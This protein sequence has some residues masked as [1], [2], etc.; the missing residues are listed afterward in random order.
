[1]F[2]FLTMQEN[3]R[4]LYLGFCD[5]KWTRSG[6]RIWLSKE[7]KCRVRI[8]GMLLFC[9]LRAQFSK[10]A[11]KLPAMRLRVCSWNWIRGKQGMRW[12]IKE[13]MPNVFIG[14]L[15]QAV[16]SNVLSQHEFSFLKLKSTWKKHFLCRLGQMWTRDEAAHKERKYCMDGLEMLLFWHRQ[17]APALQF[18]MR[19]TFLGMQR[20]CARCALCNNKWIQGPQRACL[21]IQ[22]TA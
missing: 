16:S 4:I 3:L 9:S 17:R 15:A 10:V 5:S 19:F 8:L 21:H 13:E 18:I 1:M 20:S 6:R 2:G 14:D 12:R 22:K 11:E 7:K